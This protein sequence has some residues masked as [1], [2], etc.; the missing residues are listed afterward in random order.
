MWQLDWLF[1]HLTP[2]ERPNIHAPD[3]DRVAL[4]DNSHSLPVVHDAS[5]LTSP[6]SRGGESSEL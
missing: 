3:G 6:L 5:R 4:D 1:L 2:L